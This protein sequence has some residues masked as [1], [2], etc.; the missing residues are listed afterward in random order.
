M[1]KAMPMTESAKAIKFR[2]LAEKR[3]TRALNTIR[4]IGNLSRRGSYTYSTSQVAKIFETLQ[5][6]LDAAELKFTDPQ[7]AVFKLD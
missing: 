4:R 7:Q 1:Q 3:V 2:T 6:E 5:K